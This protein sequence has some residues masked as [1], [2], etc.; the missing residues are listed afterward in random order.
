[1]YHA[2]EK[3]KIERNIEQK[4]KEILQNIRFTKKSLSD[5]NLE[6]RAKDGLRFLTVQMP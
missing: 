5:R 1:M 6:E 3:R 4:L 2:K